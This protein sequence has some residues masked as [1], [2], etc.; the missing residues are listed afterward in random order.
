MSFPP[1]TSCSLTL[2][3]LPHQPAR[4]P[5][6]WERCPAGRVARDRRALLSGPASPPRPGRSH[7][8]AAAPSPPGP[9]AGAPAGG[10]SREGSSLWRSPSPS[11]CLRRRRWCII[12]RRRLPTPSPPGKAAGSPARLPRPAASPRRPFPCRPLTLLPRP[13]RPRAPSSHGGRL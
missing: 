5:P 12:P 2:L 6:G 1:V 8:A 11:L 3:P 4:G 9:P 13:Q 7:T 10:L